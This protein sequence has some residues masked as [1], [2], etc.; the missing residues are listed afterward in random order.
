[1]ITAEARDL[2]VRLDVRKVVVVAVHGELSRIAVRVV[3]GQRR[4]ATRATVVLL[5]ESVR[6]PAGGD[7]VFRLVLSVRCVV[8]LN[9]RLDF[10][11][12]LCFYFR[13]R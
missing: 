6:N 5:L 7:E 4:V 3:Q 10:I 2:T 9:I 8:L 13:T 1:M 12:N 11:S